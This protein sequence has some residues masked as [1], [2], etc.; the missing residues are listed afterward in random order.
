MKHYLCV[1]LGTDCMCD[2]GVSDW[3]FTSVGSGPVRAGVKR[4]SGTAATAAGRRG[5]R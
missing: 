4:C 3:Y 1:I 5:G 2:L